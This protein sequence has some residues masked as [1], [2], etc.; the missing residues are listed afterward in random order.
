VVRGLEL[1][2][3]IVKLC[4]QIVENFGNNVFKLVFRQIL[5]CF[6]T[7]L[8]KFDNNHFLLFPLNK[9]KVKRILF[10]SLLTRLRI[11]ATVFCPEK[12]KIAL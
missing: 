4:L 7:T 3:E 5:I 8:F 9:V 12:S 2:I 11:T 1:T 6:A 10:L